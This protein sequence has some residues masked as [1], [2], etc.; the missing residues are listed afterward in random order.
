[1]LRKCFITL[2][3]LFLWVHVVLAEDVRISDLTTA[4]TLTGT[5]LL[6]VVQGGVT[7]NTTV[8]SILAGAAAQ[9]KFNVTPITY[10]NSPYT[11]A[12]TDAI[13]TCNATSGAVII[14]LP[15]ATGTGRYI[16]IK[17][18]DSTT[19][20]CIPTRA[21]SDTIDGA[22]SYSLTIQY[23]ASNVIDVVS[24]TWSRMH[25]NQVGGDVSGIS[26]NETVTKI[27]GTS[28]AGLATGI[29]KNTIT[30]GVPSIASAGTD[31]TS[32]TGTETLTNKRL[33]PRILSAASY[34]TGT[35]TS[36]NCDTLDQ[37]IVT[38]QAG[39]LKFNNPTG[40]PTDGQKLFIAVTGTAA[41]ALT[42]D[43]QFEASTVALPTTTATTARLNIG[44]I[45][46]ADTSKWVCVA[47]S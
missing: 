8:A 44:F 42:W 6:P 37:F 47:V 12:S 30:T 4:T 27:N 33:T 32:P 7:K 1:M 11:V 46:R 16:S 35:G 26:T 28:L 21:G 10:S 29:L 13:I 38:A 40:T 22:T 18:I 31:Y 41:R 23:A 39:A 25:V 34:T 3:S 17:K 19:N 14:N 24:G 20:A 9:L 2:F 15:A 43:T 45:W 5:E 36:L